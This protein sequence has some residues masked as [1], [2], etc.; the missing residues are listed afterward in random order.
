MGIGYVTCFP[1]LTFVCH[2]NDIQD[3]SKAKDTLRTISREKDTAGGK[4]S[5]G[6]FLCFLL[7]LEL[8]FILVCMKWKCTHMDV[9]R[10]CSISLPLIHY[11]THKSRSQNA[12][13]TFHTLFFLFPESPV[14][15]VVTVSNF[16][17]NYFYFLF[18]FISQFSPC[19]IPLNNMFSSHSTP[20]ISHNTL[21]SG[22]SSKYSMV[23]TWLDCGDF[24][25]LL[26]PQFY[27]PR[28]VSHF[29]YQNIDPTH[30]MSLHVSTS[31]NVKNWVFPHPQS[32]I[33]KRSCKVLKRTETQQ[34]TI[35]DH[36]GNGKKSTFSSPTKNTGHIRNIPHF[37]SS[38]CST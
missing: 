35:M 23:F 12:A 7:A 25:L 3:S 8:I 32:S 5:N 6:S 22:D 2:L 9:F 19:V 21:N 30:L 38:I 11:R 10:A 27:V 29:K 28:R 17:P 36:K 4:T 16:I 34:G 14:W 18:I 31:C 33:N 37:N 24:G 26:L 13:K 15:L 20:R 1:A